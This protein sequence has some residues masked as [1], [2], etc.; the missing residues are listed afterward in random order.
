MLAAVV[1][2]AMGVVFLYVVPTLRADLIAERLDRLQTVAPE[3]SSNT[4]KRCATRSPGG[5]WSRPGAPRSGRRLANAKVGIFKLDGDQVIATTISYL[6]CLGVGPD[7]PIVR[8][9]VDVGF[10]IRQRPRAVACLVVAFA[11]PVGEPTSLVVLTPAAGATSTRPPPWSSA[12][13]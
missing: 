13:S 12:R 11:E 9:A 2:T 5:G 1:A 7:E 10:G 8:R 3:S 6:A 4:D